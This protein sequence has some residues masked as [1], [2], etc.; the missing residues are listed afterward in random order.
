MPSRLR[1]DTSTPL[2]TISAPPSASNR[3]REP[4][5]R[6]PSSELLVLLTS[7]PTAGDPELMQVLDIDDRRWSSFMHAWPDASPFHHPRWARLL[8]DCYGYR[9]LALALTDRA[10]RVAAGLPVLDVGSRFGRRRWV[11]LPFTDSCP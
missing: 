11:S 9:P 5:F 8:A 4:D 2:S 10:G 3:Q 6:F 7:R 1:S